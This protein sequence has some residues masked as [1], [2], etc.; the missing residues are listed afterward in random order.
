MQILC[1]IFGHNFE[2]THIHLRK[3]ISLM[4]LH[5]LAGKRAVCKRCYKTWCDLPYEG[6]D[7]QIGWTMTDVISIKK[8]EASGE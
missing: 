6:V 8:S 5:P 7:T 1:W 2:V 4:W 3:S